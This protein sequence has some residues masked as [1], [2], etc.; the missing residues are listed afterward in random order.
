MRRPRQRTKLTRDERA[1]LRTFVKSVKASVKG[2]VG[3]SRT[4]R[5]VVAAAPIVEGLTVERSALEDGRQARGAGRPKPG[6]A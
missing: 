2:I 1:V 4:A 5:K 3:N 6:S